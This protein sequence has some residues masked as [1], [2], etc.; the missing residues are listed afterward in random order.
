MGCIKI[1]L[2]C[3]CLRVLR[4][5][6][7]NHCEQTV[8]SCIHKCRLKLY[9]AKKKYIKVKIS[10]SEITEI[11]F[12]NDW[13]LRWRGDALLS[14]STC[15]WHGWLSYLWRHNKK[16]LECNEIKMNKAAWILYRGRMGKHFSFKTATKSTE[17]LK[18][19]EVI[20]FFFFYFYSWH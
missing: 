5:R 8:H 20:Q 17:L 12:R 14:E 2:L 11:I 10:Q 9:N 7:E 13:N 19:E 1:R 18:K 15:I 3:K 4:S 16:Y 6:C